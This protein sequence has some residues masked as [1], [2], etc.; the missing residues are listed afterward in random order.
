M[1]FADGAA[2]VS[3]A[4]GALCAESFGST[5]LLLRALPGRSD[6]PRVRTA[7]AT[8]ASRACRPAASG[9]KRFRSVDP[10]LR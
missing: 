1:V 2:R 10:K 9:R 3:R 4:L 6:L 7:G 8:Q 5:A